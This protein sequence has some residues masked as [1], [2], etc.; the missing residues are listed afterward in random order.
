LLPSVFR[1][2]RDQGFGG[3]NG[4][5]KKIGHGS[6]DCGSVAFSAVSRLYLGSAPIHGLASRGGGAALTLRRNGSCGTCGGVRPNRGMR[7]GSGD[8]E[9]GRHAGNAYA[10]KRVNFR[11]DLGTL[12]SQKEITQLCDLE[13]KHISPNPQLIF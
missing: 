2:I 12:L 5:P 4:F 7:R 6:F 3:P 13:A 9:G 1:W 8:V 10:C 11:H